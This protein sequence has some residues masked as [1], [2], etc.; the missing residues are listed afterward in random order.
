MLKH[1]SALQMLT[2]FLEL[3]KL[4]Q[5]NNLENILTP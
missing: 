1:F 4:L 2:P 3:K 5:Y